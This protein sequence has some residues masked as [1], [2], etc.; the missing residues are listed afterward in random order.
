MEWRANGGIVKTRA[1]NKRYA[2]GNGRKKRAAYQR[3]PV[4]LAYMDNYRKSP[5]GKAANKR[6]GASPLGKARQ[7]RY[8]RT[9]SG[10]LA[11]ARKRAKR[12]TA[13]AVDPTLTTEEWTAI[14]TLAEGRCAYCQMIKPL[15]MDHIIPLSRGGR[16]TKENVIPACRSCNARKKNHLLEEIFDQFGL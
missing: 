2:M 1:A 14:L 8:F 13:I 15:T 12:Y 11:M 9:M 4:R 16:H 3:S 7:I 10:K 6:A 5:E